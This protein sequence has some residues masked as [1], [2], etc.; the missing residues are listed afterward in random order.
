VSGHL[1]RVE[2]GFL[3]RDARVRWVFLA[4]VLLC[5]PAF[6]LA[7]QD[8]RRVSAEFQQITAVE[9][10]RWLNQS[11]KNPHSADHF[12][13]WVFKPVSPLS[14]LDR[15]IMPYLGQMVRIEA[16]VFNDAV[17]QSVQDANSGSRSGVSSVADITQILLPLLM[18]V[19]GFAVFAADRERGTIRLALGNGTSPAKWVAARLWATSIIAAVAILLPLAILGSVSVLAAEGAGWQPWLRLV[20]WVLAHALYGGIFLLLGFAIS[21]ASKTVRS[22]LTAALLAWVVLCIAVPR[23]STAFVEFISPTP[24]YQDTRTAIERETR[25][26]NAAEIAS[27][28]EQ[29]FLQSYGA[30]RAED[31]PVDLRGAML[32]ARDEHDNRVFDK[33]FGQFFSELEAQDRVFGWM[34]IVS[35]KNALEAVS[36][37]ITGNDFANHT[38]FVWAAETYRRNLSETMNGVLMASPQKEGVTIKTSR[39]VWEEVPPFDHQPRTVWQALG[40]VLVPAGI[41]LGWLLA[42]TILVYRLSRRMKP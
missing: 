34:G 15:G 35:P 8:T 27:T 11:P 2:L 13:T 14:P 6:I 24:S 26:F 3:L 25:A 39:E 42:A 21:L 18:F 1:R 32:H 33:W 29:E 12:G 9:R 17:F 41:L 16:H 5:L 40:G 30:E 31:L 37:A 7:L 23:A 22:A 38:S 10:D 36:E 4:F 28:R 20:L 19:L